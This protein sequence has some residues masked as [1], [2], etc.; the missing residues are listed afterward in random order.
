MKTL[1]LVDI[2]ND[3]LPGGALPVPEG[4]AVIPLANQLLRHFELSVATRDWHPPNHGSFAAN[5]PEHEVGDVIELDGLEQ[6]LWP[7]HCVQNTRGAAFRDSLDASR[8]DHIVSKGDDPNIDAYS[9]FFDNGHRR[10]TDL[11]DFLRQR[12]ATDLFVMGLATDYCVKATA[13]DARRLGFRTWLIEDGCRGIGRQ[14]GD[15]QAATHE[16]EQAGVV[17]V[18][19]EAVLP[20]E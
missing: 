20:E 16:M 15:V 3:F 10:A 8:I 11:E 14:P 1:I 12:A 18:R 7:V 4:D 19:S 6:V 5:H 17:V 9:G 2:Q 13:L